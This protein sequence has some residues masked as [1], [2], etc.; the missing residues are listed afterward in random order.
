MKPWTREGVKG[1]LL[2]RFYVR[3]HI[4]LILGS[5][6][7]AAMLANWALHQIG[8]TSMLARY[9]AAIICSYLV[10]LFS[11]WLWLHYVGIRRFGDSGSSAVDAGD[12]IG[13][14]PTPSGGGGGLSSGNL[15][16][17]ARG[18]TLDGGGA[19]AS[20]A[21][22]Q[23]AAGLRMPAVVAVE[24]KAGLD[25][26]AVADGADGDFV[27]VIL[28]IALIA[29]IFVASGYIIWAGPEILAEAAFGALLAGGLAKR[30]KHEDAT[31]WMFGVVKKTWWPFAIVLVIAVTFAG[32]CAATYPQATTFKEAFAAA[33]AG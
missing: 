24:D 7:L 5:A 30:A 15:G 26:S 6:A 10:F 22:G 25:V 21:E 16:S 12:E 11:I 3:F 27:L 31:G 29:A 4:T 28:A 13:N 14:L 23:S 20:W 19:S 32:Y 9:P 8:V 33:S 2:K 1:A 18:G 17:I